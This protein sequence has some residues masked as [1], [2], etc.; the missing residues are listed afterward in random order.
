LISESFKVT[1]AAD[2]SGS[3]FLQWPHLLIT[4]AFFFQKKA[5]Q[6]DFIYTTMG[7][8]TRQEFGREFAELRQ[9]CRYQEQELRLPWATQK[10]QKKKR[11]E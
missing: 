6:P 7:H 3:S 11:E 1:A 10:G 2:H 8:K 9:S 5:Y 4:R